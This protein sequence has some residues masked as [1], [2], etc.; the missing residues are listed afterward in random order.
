TG[1]AQ[2]NHRVGRPPASD[3]LP[4]EVWRPVTRNDKFDR[5][6]LSPRTRWTVAPPERGQATGSSRTARL[7]PLRALPFRGQ[8]AWQP[9]PSSPSDSRNLPRTQGGDGRSFTGVRAS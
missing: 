8:N 7:R 5:R 1:G 9:P 3:V 2:A 6:R 4:G